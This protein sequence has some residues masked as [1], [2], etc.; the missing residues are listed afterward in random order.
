MLLDIGVANQAVPDDQLSKQVIRRC[1]RCGF[2]TSTCPTYV[3]LGDELDSPR[4][5]IALIK[6]MLSSDAP[7]E[8]EA[9]KHIDRCLS[10]LS[11][12]T[13]CPSGVS[14]RQLIDHAR[15]HIETHFER[16]LPE[17]LTRSLLA[18]ILPY[19]GRFAVALGLAKV[20]TWLKPVFASVPALRSV[21]EM[22]S[23]AA[24]APKRIVPVEPGLP[25]VVRHKVAMLEGCVEPVLGGNIQAAARR[26]L[27]RMECEIVR[28]DTGCCGALSH[29]LGKSE[30]ALAMARK[31]VDLWHGAIE[32]GV[33]VIV[34]TASGCGSF[35]RDYGHLLRE[36]EVYARRAQVVS[37]HIRDI[38]EVVSMFGLPEAVLADLPVV[39]YHSACTLQHGQGIRDLPAQLLQTVGF[40]VRFPAESHLCCG[41][42]GVYNILQ[43]ELAIQL[44]ERKAQKLMETNPDIIATG[45]IGCLTQIDRYAGVPVVHT[46]ELLDWATGG[47]KPAGI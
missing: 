45:N 46:V 5:R 17:R 6:D 26:L 3:L 16:P 8:P 34:V 41:S 36:D 38:S 1:V 30:Q 22:L 19:R 2:C 32:N 31:H 42:A 21:A 39:T 35:M 37:A 23:L 33:E 11:C 29:H 4:G 24:G 25:A 20:F 27:A 43:P 14:Y 28:V 10:C 9:V 44:G 7:P 47:E 40:E 12:E 13:T 18:H 15:V